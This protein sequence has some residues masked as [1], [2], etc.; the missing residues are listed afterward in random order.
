M[1]SLQNKVF[2]GL[3]LAVLICGY[4][5]PSEL[6]AKHIGFPHVKMD[7]T[8]NKIS[9]WEAL[10]A[11]E[12]RVIQASTLSAVDSVWSESVTISLPTL[13]PTRP[14]LAVNEQGDAVVVW[15]AVNEEKG[16]C[17]L[18]AVM[19]PYNGSWTS[20]HMLSTNDE[21]V[22]HE[23]HIEL[24][25]TGNILVIWNAHKNGQ[26]CVFSASSTMGSSWSTPTAICSGE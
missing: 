10:D 22:A 3:W 24:N 20:P 5:I 8:G 7:A 9:V 13:N 17:C 14:Q 6:Y 11:K 21:D 12:T 2:L 25:S 19:K 23:Y 15:T 16:I 1:R 26:D 4:V 18:Y